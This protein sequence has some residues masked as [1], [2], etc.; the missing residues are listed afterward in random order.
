MRRSTASP[1]PGAKRSLMYL[2][3]STSITSSASRVAGW[4][5]ERFAQQLSEVSAVG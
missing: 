5:R 2:K 3:R 1:T 4:S